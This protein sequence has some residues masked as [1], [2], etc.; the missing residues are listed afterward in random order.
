MRHDPL[1]S[2]PSIF[3][4]FLSCKRKLLLV[5]G[6]SDTN[7]R[8]TNPKEKNP[9]L[10]IFLPPTKQPSLAIQSGNQSASIWSPHECL[11]YPLLP[12]SSMRISIYHGSDMPIVLTQN[13]CSGS[14][15]HPRRPTGLFKCFRGHMEEHQVRSWRG[16][17]I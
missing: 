4:S 7:H 17:C 11:S 15:K 2:F 12:S 13:E 8:F 6:M 10:L 16:G 1:P 9:L 3:P 5:C 14:G